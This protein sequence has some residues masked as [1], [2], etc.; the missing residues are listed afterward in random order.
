[1]QH[2]H[3]AVSSIGQEG[4]LSIIGRARTQRERKSTKQKI[5]PN[6][7]ANEARKSRPQSYLFAQTLIARFAQQ[8]SFIICYVLESSY[9]VCCALVHF[10]SFA[11]LHL[12]LFLCCVVLLSLSV[13]SPLVF[14]AF[15]AIHFR[16]LLLTNMFYDFFCSSRAIFVRE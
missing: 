11:L 1:M 6:C 7:D 14:T 4:C 2:N 16:F 12:V 5:K 3:G 15:D 13:D 9:F 8:V 10:F